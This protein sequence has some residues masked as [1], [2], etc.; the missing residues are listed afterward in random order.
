MFFVPPPFLKKFM[1]VPFLRSFPGH[2][3]HKL[4]SGGPKWGV[5][6]GGQ[7]V[8]VEKVCAL[9]RSPSLDFA[10]KIGVILLCDHFS[11]NAADGLSPICKCLEDRNLLKVRTP[12]SLFPFFLSDT[13]IWG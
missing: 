6:G 4:F 9:F 3:A 5:L 10:D 11:A 7:K 12:D 2:E 1:W 8:Y 13:S